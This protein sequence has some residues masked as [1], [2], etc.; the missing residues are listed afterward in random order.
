M[1]WNGKRLADKIVWIPYY[2]TYIFLPN[3]APESHIPQLLTAG[4]CQSDVPNI[5]NFSLTKTVYPDPSWAPPHG[6]WFS[7]M[8]LP[9]TQILKPDISSA[10]QEQQP[11]FIP[12]VLWTW[13]CSIFPIDTYSLVLI[14]LVHF[15]I[16]DSALHI[17]YIQKAYITGFTQQTI[18]S[19]R[20]GT[21]SSHFVSSMKLSDIPH[22]AFIVQWQRGQTI[23]E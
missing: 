3:Y 22:I 7:K 20:V 14:G 4:Y 16:S 13:K 6:L 11:T 2:S 12:Q 8:A 19:L 9:H 5:L 21:G 23:C 18:S 17:A 15:Y 1:A 10:S